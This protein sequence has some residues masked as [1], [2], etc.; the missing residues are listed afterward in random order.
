MPSPQ[1]GVQSLGAVLK[2]ESVSLND[3]PSVLRSAW[4][5]RISYTLPSVRPKLPALLLSSV[6]EPF[7][8]TCG[9][10]RSTASLRL[11]NTQTSSSPVKSSLA[12][13]LSSYLN[14]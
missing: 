7:S 11:T 14:Q 3:E 6:T 5:T 2:P 10:P 4:N 1:I 8:G 12:E 9:P 13:P